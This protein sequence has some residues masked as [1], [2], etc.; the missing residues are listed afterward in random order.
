MSLVCQPKLCAFVQFQ[1]VNE[2]IHWDVSCWNDGTFVDMPNRQDPDAAG[3]AASTL[4]ALALNS[5][6]NVSNYAG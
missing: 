1:T 4:F 2:D 3:S 6:F 5:W